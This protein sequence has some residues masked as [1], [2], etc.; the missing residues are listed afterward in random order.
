[1]HGF[2]IWRG[3]GERRP[4]FRQEMDGHDVSSVEG[5]ANP[6]RR[7]GTTLPSPALRVRVT[8]LRAQV[9]RGMSTG[10]RDRLQGAG[11]RTGHESPIGG[12][13]PRPRL[14]GARVQGREM[15]SNQEHTNE[16]NP[17]ALHA[18]RARPHF[19]WASVPRRPSPHASSASPQVRRRVARAAAVPPGCRS[20]PAPPQP[21]AGGLSPARVWFSRCPSAPQRRISSC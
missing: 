10:C 8:F 4:K 2:R 9:C 14:S 17:G 16:L 13:R 7:R 6:K 21:V 11:Q 12:G 20:T 1:M 15:T 5:R 3:I 18:V 19:A